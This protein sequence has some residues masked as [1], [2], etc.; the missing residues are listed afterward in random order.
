M[1]HCKG[2]DLSRS[3]RKKLYKGVMKPIHKTTDSMG[4]THHYSQQPQ[5]NTN[6]N[7]GRRTRK[8]KGCKKPKRPR[9]SRRIRYTRKT[10]RYK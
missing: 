4:L 3:I 2:G 6:T 5:S 9:M 1:R 10:R 8:T 7:G